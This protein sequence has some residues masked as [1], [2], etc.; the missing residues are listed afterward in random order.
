[1]PAVALT[2]HGTMYGVI[3]FY[4]NS[5]ETKNPIEETEEVKYINPL[6]GCE[7]Y[8]CEGDILND[9]ET[10]LER[11]HLILIAKNNEGYQNLIK[12]DSIAATQGFYYKPRINH[13]LLKKYSKGLICLS[14]CIQGEVSKN[15]LDGNIDKAYEKLKWYH[16]TFGDDYYIELQDHGLEEEKRVNPTLIK[17]AKEFNIPMVITNDSHYLLAQDALWHDTL[18]CEQTKSKKNEPNRFKFSNNE[19][20]VKTVEE[21]RRAFSWM[22][23]VTFNECI[24]NTVKVADKCHVEIELGK[25]HLPSYPVPVG[26]TE[27]TYFDYLCREGLKK[28]YGDKDGN[29]PPDIEERYLYEKSVI[30][31][32][33]FPAYFLLTWDFVNWAKNQGIPV[34]PGRGSAAGSIVAYALGITELDPI[35]HHLLFERF[36]NPERISMPDIDI[37]FCKRRRGE[38]IDYVTNKYGED[39]VCQIITFGTLAAKLQLKQL[40]EFMILILRRVTKFPEWFRQPPE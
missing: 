11:Y 36:L 15:I 30:D 27:E 12:L 19:F 4:L 17:M 28:N 29:I 38:V 10:H 32:M 14:A 18:L 25:S 31:K 5:K 8:I 23:E 37:D 22:D 6:I 26:Y 40:Q 16:D 1:M 20:Y 7:F 39:H 3:D 35:R 21:L 13:E 9:H 24:E 34:G 33:G 2:D